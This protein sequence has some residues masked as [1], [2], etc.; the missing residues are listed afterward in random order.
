MIKA[1]A[2]T[3]IYHRGNE[4]IK[5]LKGVSFEIGQ[6]DFAILFGPSGA[7]KTS[8][9]N[10]LGGMDSPDAGHVEISG[11]PINWR[12]LFQYRRKNVGFIFSEF[13]LISTLTGLEN[14]LLPQIWTGKV[15]RERG[16]ELLKLV[17]LEHR[18][19]HYPKELSGGEMQRVAIARALI[20]EPKILLADEPTAN[21]D[22][23]TRD[24]IVKFFGQ[25]AEKKGITILFATHD[26]EI[27]KKSKQVIHL[28][29]GRVIEEQ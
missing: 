25:L 2:L 17:D 19:N 1:K 8:V 24:L 16:R 20:N 28:S 15:N 6:G 29:E 26:P 14:V 23:R 3:K 7:G 5:A 22:T 13:H 11:S 4:K 9:L 27:V 10:I 12:K 18:M 21:L